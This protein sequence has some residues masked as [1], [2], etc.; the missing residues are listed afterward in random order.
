MKNRV[1]VYVALLI[2]HCSLFIDNAFALGGG[3]P[4]PDGAGAPNMLVTMFP[5]ILM[6]L[7]LYL[8]IIRPQQKKQKDHQAMV[9]ELKKGDRVVTSGGVH[10][11][12][13]GVKEKEGVVV[14]QVAKDVQIEVSRGN[15]SRVAE[16]KGK[17]K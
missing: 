16:A 6:F 2:V 12:I 4:S 7:I 1:W 8:L 9:D 5:F 17:K 15:I 11:T 3:Q 10:G 14:V 13:T